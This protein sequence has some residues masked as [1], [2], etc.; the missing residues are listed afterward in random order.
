MKAKKIV[1]LGISVVFLAGSVA[2]AALINNTREPT[3]FYK[4]HTHENGEV[5]GAPSHSGGT[6]SY[7]CHNGSVPYHCH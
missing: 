6:D 5:I 2:Y 7:G 4:G 3:E 1:L